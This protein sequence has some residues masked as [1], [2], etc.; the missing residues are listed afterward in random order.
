M[1]TVLFQA[2][3]ARGTAA[4]LPI[5]FGKRILVLAPHPDDEVVGACAAVGRAQRAGARVF[6]VRTQTFIQR[7][8]NDELFSLSPEE[9]KQKR[10]ALGMYASE[11]GNLRSIG[12]ERESFRPLKQYDYAI[13]A[14]PGRLFYQRFQWAPRH[15]RVDYCHP[16]AVCAALVGFKRRRS[17]RDN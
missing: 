2:N 1:P 7:D 12:S 5:M 14:H 3:F 9:S 11:R 13:P 10:R 6:V 4:V 15:P 17:W 8:R 16:L